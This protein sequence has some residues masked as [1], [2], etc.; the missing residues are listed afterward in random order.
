MFLLPAV[1]LFVKKGVLK[2][3]F[4]AQFPLCLSSLPTFTPHCPLS[5]L[6]HCIFSDSLFSLFCSFK[7]LSPSLHPNT[8]CTHSSGEFYCSRNTR[9]SLNS[10]A[11]AIPSPVFPSPP[12]ARNHPPLPTGSLA[13][14]SLNHLLF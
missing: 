1:S 13:S 12:S 14:R 11:P 6:C 5:A 4:P 9:L 3:H 10:A 2:K 8:S 7:L